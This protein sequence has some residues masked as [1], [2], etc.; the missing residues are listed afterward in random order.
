MF[1]AEPRGPRA[2]GAAHEGVRRQQTCGACIL[3]AG[4]AH[5]A[6]R[7]RRARPSRMRRAKPQ[8]ERSAP[9]LM[10]SS[11]PRRAPRSPSPG[12]A[13][14]ISRMAPRSAATWSRPRWNA[15]GIEPARGRRRAHGLRQSRRR[16]RLQHRAADRAARRLPG[17]D[18]RH[19]GESLL[20]V[21]PADHRAGRATH[22]GGRGRGVRRGR[23]RIDLLRA[24]RAPEH[25]HG[26]GSL[27]RRAQ[28]RDLLEHAADR[29]DRGAA[30]TR[31]RARR[32][33]DTACRASSAP[34]RRRPPGGSPR[35][36]SPS[37][38]SWARRTRTAAAS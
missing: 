24:E 9:W 15:R 32:R 18:F 34:P 2:G 16:H 26:E 17:H 5:R 4:E 3:E 6:A 8:E 23:R 37:K 21:G 10:P 7:G 38:W 36:S 1:H 14:S 20:L 30:A 31:F 12:A 13:P 33:I 22:H 27:A 19:D 29:G 28:A 35:K 11:F 25:L